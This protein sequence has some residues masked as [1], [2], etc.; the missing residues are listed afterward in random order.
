M[1]VKKAASRAGKAQDL[2]QL[3]VRIPTAIFKKLGHHAVEH[4]EKTQ[5]DHVAAALQEYLKDSK[6]PTG[7]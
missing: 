5:A 7:K 1:K 6:C 3:N 4:P 2:S